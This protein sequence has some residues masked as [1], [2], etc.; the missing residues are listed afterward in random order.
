MLLVSDVLALVQIL[1]F[2]MEISCDLFLDLTIVTS[3]YV[4]ETECN[5][6]LRK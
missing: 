4:L 2:E 5:T 3:V 1:M 6:Q